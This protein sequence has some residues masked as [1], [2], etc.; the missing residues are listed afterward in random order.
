MGYQ[1]E[2]KHKPSIPN[3]VKYWQVFED[4]S[5][6]NSFLA[7]KD[8]FESLAIDEDKEEERVKDVD[9]NKDVLLTLIT[10]KEII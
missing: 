7:L 6:I 1:I 3:N 2:V 9:Q 8:E 10:E 5:H 4:D